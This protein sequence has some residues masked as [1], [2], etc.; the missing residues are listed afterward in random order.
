MYFISITVTDCESN[1]ET[2]VAPV[3]TDVHDGMI[4]LFFLCVRAIMC[5]FISITVTDCQCDTETPVVVPV[6]TNVHDGKVTLFCVCNFKLMR[7]D[8]DNAVLLDI[9]LIAMFH[10]IY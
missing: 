2:I 5:T 4:T 6:D 1:I 8:V 9:L 3:E 7:L 10:S